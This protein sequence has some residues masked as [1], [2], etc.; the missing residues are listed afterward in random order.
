MS[1]GKRVITVNGIDVDVDTQAL[2]IFDIDEAQRT[3]AAQMAFW[4]SVWGSAE[5]EREAADAHYRE[6]RAKATE[7]V[8]S[9]DPKAAEWKVKAAIEA[10]PDFVKL[11]AALARAIDHSLTAKGMYESWAKRAN[12]AQSLGAA[13]REV[14]RKTGE[15]TTRASDSSGSEGVVKE[16][17]DIDKRDRLKA[18]LKKKP[19]SE[20]VTEDG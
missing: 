5:G 17:H 4:A 10:H 8:L 3:S 7:R 15:G 6:W 20:R 16:R 9:A 13:S 11:K 14:L 19:A 12:L 2:N 1:L 18:A